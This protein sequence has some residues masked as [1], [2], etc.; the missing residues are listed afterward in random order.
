MLLRAIRVRHAVVHRVLARQ[1]GDD[2]RSRDVAPEI[3]DQV[4]EVVFFLRSN[5]AV[6]EEDVGTVARQTPYGV[7][8]IDPGIHARRR[9]ELGPGGPE[10]GGYDGMAGPQRVE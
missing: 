5:G 1:E 10:L 7:V 9:F 3:D 6:R 4:P 2:L 8:G